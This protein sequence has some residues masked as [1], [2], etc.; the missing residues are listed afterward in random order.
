MLDK[1]PPEILDQV[2]S[3]LERADL[4]TVRLVCK[5]LSSLVIPTLF[6]TIYIS[7]LTLNRLRDLSH[8]AVISRAVEEVQYQEMRFNVATDNEYYNSSRRDLLCKT[9]TSFV[10]SKEEDEYEATTT[11]KQVYED[12]EKMM[13]RIWTVLHAYQSKANLQDLRHIYAAFRDT[14]PNLTQLRRFISIEADAGGIAL[15]YPGMEND[16]VFQDLR[17]FLP[18][19]DSMLRTFASEE[20]RSWPA[21]GFMAAW[22][23][24]SDK[25]SDSSLE[26]L[27][28]RRD[29]DLFCKGGVSL[30]RYNVQDELVNGFRNLTTLSLYLE[31]DSQ[32]TE[33]PGILVAALGNASR[34]K[35]LEI[36]LVSWGETHP[37]RQRGSLSFNYSQVP[38]GHS[39]VPFN[40]VLPFV[41]FPALEA[42][43]FEDMDMTNEEICS[44]L[45]MQPKLRRLTL[46][47]PYL[48]GRWTEVLQ[49]LSQNPE[50]VLDAFDLIHP[51]DH[52]RRDRE[53]AQRDPAVVTVPSRVS[54]AAILD[55]V[56][57]EGEHPLENR[58]WIFFEQP[59]LENGNWEDYSD[60]S[61][62]RPE[63]HELQ[64][65]DIDPAEYDEDYD[66]DAE[67]S[68]DGDSDIEMEMEQGDGV[69]G[70]TS[71]EMSMPLR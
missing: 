28:I 44:W 21:H 43:T 18:V 71:M 22:R 19:T 55:F 20:D 70:W 47:R 58:R 8:H 68:E 61:E 7:C 14:L 40:N 5:Q 66:F 67:E 10:A 24:L 52:E 41:A 49:M 65:A 42:V 35:K 46:I 54:S 36:R 62:W 9:I 1:V 33:S 29:S 6:R 38:F 59:T 26:H 56:N 48:Q 60:R 27:E 25:D 17:E 30:A 64:D 63:D 3:S 57:H 34:L 13:D 51:W 15:D 69:D 39:S 12:E 53:E 23:F 11:Y 31:V 45:L 37:P 4:Q 2:L 16:D 32:L 50:F